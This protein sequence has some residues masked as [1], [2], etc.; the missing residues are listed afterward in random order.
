MIKDWLKCSLFNLMLVL[1]LTGCVNSSKTFEASSPVQEVKL[2]SI[3]GNFRQLPA[4][5]W[6]SPTCTAAVLVIDKN[7]QQD[8]TSLGNE[9][10]Q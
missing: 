4:P 8:L 3:P 1:S 10:S 7:S 9:A 5:Q 2:P 6:C